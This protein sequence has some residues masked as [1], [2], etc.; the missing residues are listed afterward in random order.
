RVFE[1]LATAT[2]DGAAARVLAEELELPGLGRKDCGEALD[3]MVASLGELSVST[4]DSLY[5]RMT[6]A[7]Q[8]EL[9]LADVPD[10]AALEEARVADVRRSALQEALEGL[11]S[12]SWE[13]LLAL[14]G[15][16]HGGAS[17]RAVGRSLDRLL[18]D[19][20]ESFREAPNREVWGR[21]EVPEDVTDEAAA[22][23]AR[24]MESALAG[25]GPGPLRRA[26]AADLERVRD[27]DWLRLVA[28]G[29]GPVLLREGDR[30]RYRGARVPP[31]W[32]SFYAPLLERAR[33]RLLARAKERTVATW[34]LLAHFDHHFR[35]AK[36]GAGLLLFGD[37]AGELAAWLQR[38]REDAVEDLYYRLDGRIV[39]LLI[40]E[41]Q[42][43]SRDQWAVLR[44]VAKEIRSYGDG[45]R[46]FFCVGDPKQAIYGWRGGCADLLDDL[47]TDLGLE[48]AV[49]TLDLSYR[50]ATTVLEAVNAVFGALRDLPCLAGHDEAVAAWSEGFRRHSS[51]R[52]EAP[53]Y[54]EMRTGGRGEE[55]AAATAVRLGVLAD[56]WPGAELAVLVPTNRQVALHLDALRSAGLPAAG[57]GGSRIVDD[58]AVSLLVA[59]LRLAERPGDRLSAFH[60]H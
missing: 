39:H 9:G 56:R 25:S 3:L 43:T 51:A 26:L 4:L 23:A 16:L 47:E 20:Y 17:R 22:A 60:L 8:V 40:D 53:G 34:E 5:F 48:G 49:E 19:L 36:R 30:L 55:H 24:E 38:G 18:L 58:A 41:F 11:A 21:L 6:C 52:P 12:E 15:R 28:A 35:A 27:E 50:S 2:L 59:A 42:D 14:L 33:H 37:L 29:L 57:F 10:V 45:S 46:S 1:R 32:R 31:A 7:L 54:V 13:E 44:P